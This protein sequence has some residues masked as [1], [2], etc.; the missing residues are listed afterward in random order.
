M[1][2][3]Y[4]WVVN[5][6]L[7]TTSF[8]Y[9]TLNYPFQ[10]I[11]DL[12]DGNYR[13]TG[14]C[15]LL[16]PTYINYLDQTTNIA[17]KDYVDTVTYTYL[18]LSSMATTWYVYLGFYERTC[19]LDMTIPVGNG[20]ASALKIEYWNGTAWVQ[21]SGFSDGTINSGCTIAQSATISWAPVGEGLEQ[22]T[23]ISTTAIND[24][25]YFYRL[26]VSATL[27]TKVQIDYI[28]G[29][30]CPRTIHAY[31]FPVYA[32]RRL[33]LCNSKVGQPNEVLVSAT[34]TNVVFNGTDSTILYVGDTKDIVAASPIYQRT[35]NSLYENVVFC[36]ENS[37]WILNGTDPSSYQLYQLSDSIGCNAPDSMRLCDIGLDMNNIPKQVIIWQSAVGWVVCDGWTI[38]V[39]SDDVKN[40]F[41]R[42][43]SDTLNASVINKTSVFYDPFHREA[44][45]LCS[46]GAVTTKNREFVYSIPK[47]KFFEI[48]RT[49]TEY[50]QVGIIVMDTVGNSYNYGFSYDGYM[51]RLEYGTTFDGYAITSSFRTGDIP[52]AG[53]GRSSILRK[54]KLITKA[55][56]TT[57]NKISV[58]CYTDTGSSSTLLGSLS[59]ADSTHRVVMPKLSVS[60]GEHNFYSIECS[61]STNNEVYG[62]EPIGMHLYLEKGREDI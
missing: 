21:V 31:K 45:F 26:S 2:Y 1:L 9:I 56:N 22:V 28:Q 37:T 57:T 55:R 50:I 43:S 11:N 62:F 19:A 25:L 20:N 33:F 3:W 48:N 42:N 60:L 59:I 14:K 54:I 47:K 5:G 40:L 35:P 34:N 39:I 23:S 17:V 6:A 38:N 53:W 4:K 29:I 36:K 30:P 13:I 58:K 8:Y 61:L 32:Q 44:H 27:S 24:K 52:A 12:W 51:Y 10:T 7:T 41:D 49:P 16:T 46:T 18:D 15:F